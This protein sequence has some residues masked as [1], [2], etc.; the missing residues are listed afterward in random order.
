MVYTGSIIPII[1]TGAPMPVMSER[2]RKNQPIGTPAL[3]MADTTERRS[4]RSIVGM[5][6]AIPPFCMT[7]NDVTRMNAAQPIM[8]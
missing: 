5:V 4:Q 1:A 3:P 6:S 7:N 8:W 2:V